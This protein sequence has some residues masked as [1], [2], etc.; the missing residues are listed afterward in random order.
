VPS[1]LKYP[2][3]YNRNRI[4]INYNPNMLAEMNFGVSTGVMP[5]Q[6][7]VKRSILDPRPAAVGRSETTRPVAYIVGKT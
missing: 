3:S 2:T 1:I 4:G 5:Y 7:K 6:R